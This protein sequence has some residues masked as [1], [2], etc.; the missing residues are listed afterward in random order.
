MNTVQRALLRG[1]LVA[2]VAIVCGPVGVA[3]AE[4]PTLTLESPTNG[5]VSNNRTPSFSG[6]SNDTLDDVTLNIYAGTSVEPGALLQTLPTLLP[7]LAG[8][9]SVGPSGPLADGVYTAQA[10]QTNLL[11]SETGVS[12][13][14]V[15]FTVDTV[16]PVVSLNPITSPTNDSTPTFSGSAGTAPGDIA[17]VRL[18]IYSG[19]GVSGSAIRTVGVTSSGATWTAGQVEA[20]AD[21][22]YT[23]QAEQSD[24]AGNVGVSEPPVTFT[25]DT[26]P[27]VT[28]DPV[29]RTV[30]AGEDAVFT[31]AASGSPT[32]SVQWQ[33]S[34]NGGSSWTDDTSDAG[35]TT[36]T[37]TVVATAVAESGYEYRAVFTNV[38]GPP[39]PSAPATLTVDA[40]PV[41]TSSP[42]SKAIKVGESAM[43][44]AAASGAPTPTVQWQ[45]STDLGATWVNDTTD[46]GN[47][48]GT[49]M[50]TGTTVAENGHEFRAVFTN[51]VGPPVPSAAATLTVSEKEVAPVITGNPVDQAVLEGEGTAFVATA[52]G[53]PTPS[54]QW[55]ES[56]NGGSTWTND[57]SDLGNTTGTLTILSPTV[58]K[59][60]HQY[61][62]V[63]TNV[64]EAVTST[65]ATLTVAKRTVAPI[66]TANPASQSVVASETATFT[67]AASGVPTPKVQWQE[68][69]NFGLTWTNDASDAG[70]ATGTLTVASTAVAESGYEYRA[71]FS[72]KAGTVT[73]AT[74]TLTVSAAPEVTADPASKSVM[75]GAAA[76]FTAAA[77]GVP[78]P[79]V[80]WQVSTDGGSTWANDTADAGNVTGTLTVAS[81]TVA[82]NGNEYRAMFTNAVSTAT[83][84]PA[85]LTVNA[86]PSLTIPSPPPTPA[87]TPPAAAFTWLP[88]KPTTGQSVVLVS[89][90]T[91]ADSPLTAF[92]WDVT[93]SGTF[94]AGG[95][96]I[97]TSFSTP[98]NHVVRLK[99]IDGDGLTSVATETIPVSV[100][101]LVL[102]QPFPVVRIAGSENSSGVK[103][104]LLTVQAPVGT[105]VSVTCG[106][107]HCPSRSENRV[108]V[109]SRKNSRAGGVLL[110]FGKFERSLQV[111]VV[112]EIRVSKPGEIGKYTSFR[113]RPNKAPARVDA[114]VGPTNPKPIPCPTS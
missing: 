52:S 91:D 86:P 30:R 67:A 63:F 13:P 49:L 83:T 73:S 103:I 101:P 55:Q 15:T 26:A 47:T 21:G 90:S 12:E 51:A 87:A 17:S 100:T 45:E 71:V 105:R 106:G 70:N 40:A 72:N 64:V 79:E 46:A 7:P 29:D 102:M 56:T 99:V 77:S 22:T 42:A 59:N 43:F 66:I 92:A 11:L 58:A 10:T 6:A 28:S 5:S 14:P 62:A 108:V 31:A 37:L 110:S 81:A 54:V 96:A 85:L 4:P 93:G 74:A 41:V 44:T 23:V 60:G 25:V 98:G 97:T 20:L 16:S 9:W 76:T 78:T 65:A 1:I 88:A 32:P 111:G 3:M 114:C 48:T 38:I 18:K 39:V 104:S 50:V 89:S 109:S 57:T 82:E 35:N 75:V 8:T 80:R 69:A 36:D 94:A 107:S 68:S 112:L 27:V 34:T 84:L 113:I 2:L 19:E 61:R 24:E 33:V 53:N 95:P